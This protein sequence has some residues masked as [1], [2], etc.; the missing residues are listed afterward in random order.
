M[1]LESTDIFASYYFLVFGCFALCLTS[2]SK[3]RRQCSE[4][5]LLHQGWATSGRPNC[6][7]PKCHVKGSHN[8]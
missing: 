6:K 2:A 1:L 7:M 3:P 4:F 8:K 5:L